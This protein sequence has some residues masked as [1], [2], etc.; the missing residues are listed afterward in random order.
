MTEIPG[1]GTL[2]HNKAAIITNWATFYRD[3]NLLDDAQNNRGNSAKPMLHL[4]ILEPDGM[5]TSVWNNAVVFRPRAGELGMLM[6][7]RRFD[8]D[9]LSQ[10]KEQD[11]PDAPLGKR[12][13]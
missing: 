8:S 9:M 13:V 12:I 3:V 10:R 2:L 11:G 1:F 4:P 7:S 6:I 5:I